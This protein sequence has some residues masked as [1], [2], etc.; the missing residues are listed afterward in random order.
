MIRVHTAC[1]IATMQCKFANQKKDREMAEN[2]GLFLTFRGKNNDVT[3]NLSLSLV[4]NLCM[5][6]G[7][8]FGLIQPPLSSFSF[9]WRIC[10]C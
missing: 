2:K 8:R 6:K 1:L 4:L 9:L 5:V 10:P 7:K 3:F